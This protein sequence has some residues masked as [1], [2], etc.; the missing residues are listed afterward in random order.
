MKQL[1][2][3]MSLNE[4]FFYTEDILKKNDAAMFIECKYPNGT[5]I[6]VLADNNNINLLAK[7]YQE[8]NLY[9][10]ITTLNVGVNETSQSFYSKNVCDYIIEGTGGRE[11]ELELEMIELRCI[12][13][14]PAKTI[15]SVFKDI[16]NK[17]NKD[18]EIG[19]GIQASTSL[20]KDYF[21]KKSYVGK[22]KLRIDFYNEKLPLIFPIKNQID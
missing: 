21:Y 14:S 10:F 2:I 15:V 6:K 12:S 11:N 1:N 22:K 4:L 18:V 8:K 19:K 3:V 16:K 17:L 13:K 9:F 5:R 20:Y 7:D